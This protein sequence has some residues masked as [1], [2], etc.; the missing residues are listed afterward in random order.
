[1]IALINRGTV[2]LSNAGARVATLSLSTADASVLLGNTMNVHVRLGNLSLSDDSG[3]ETASPSFKKLMFIEGEH[4]AELKYLTYEPQ[5]PETEKGINSSVSLTAASVAFHYLEQPLHDI[6]VFFMK[7]ARLKGL[8]DTA[9]E[10]A[11]QRASEIERMGFSVSVK[12]P[13]II[14]PSNPS[15]SFDSLIMRLGEITASNAY[16][17]GISRTEASL[18]GMQLVS[19]IFYEG[20]PST[21][22][23]I[24][25][26]AI[27]TEIVQ[28]GGPSN[29]PRPDTEVKMMYEV[30]KHAVL[31]EPPR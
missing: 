23:M 26:I 15:S 1:V 6:Y 9:S 18:R 22:K 24:D 4:L 16:R 12:T 29:T 11:V 30:I 31:T 3:T 20:E 19:T 5:D 8:Y 17:D 27:V 10:A 7:L 21:L 25:D 13:I 28:S 14:F 2:T